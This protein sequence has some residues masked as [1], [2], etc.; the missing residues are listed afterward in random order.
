MH[1]MHIN[2][3]INRRFP[4]GNDQVW[5]PP[6]H[7]SYDEKQVRSVEDLFNWDFRGN[8][9]TRIGANYMA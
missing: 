3:I 8:I 5:V 6:A 7:T 9:G 2:A 1:S 4:V